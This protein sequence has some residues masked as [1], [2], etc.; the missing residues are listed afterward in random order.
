MSSLRKILG[1]IFAPAVVAAA[2]AL[3]GVAATPSPAKADTYYT[4][5]RWEYRLVGYQW[6]PYTA[7]DYYGH[8][9]TAYRRVPVY[10][11]VKVYYD[12]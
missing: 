2:L 9:Y 6:V 12:Y 8:P 5:Y 3:G 10:R 11:W 4:G 7:Y 1:R